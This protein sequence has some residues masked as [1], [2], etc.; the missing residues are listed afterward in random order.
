M[1]NKSSL[2][3]TFLKLFISFFTSAE[4]DF[5]SK[6]LLLIVSIFFSVFQLILWFLDN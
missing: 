4:L 1:I 3:G 2:N 6:E 5:S